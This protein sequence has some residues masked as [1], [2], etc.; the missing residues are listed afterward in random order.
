MR[1]LFRVEVPPTMERGSY[2][3]NVGG[4]NEREARREALEEVN[5]DRTQPRNDTPAPALPRLPPGTQ[6]RPLPVDVGTSEGVRFNTTHPQ[7]YK[8]GWSNTQR[9]IRFKGFCVLCGRWT[10]GHDDGQDDPRGILGDH[11]AAELVA[12]EY[13]MSGP[14]VPACF[15]CQNDTEERYNAVL[16]IAKRRWKAD[17]IA[18]RRTW[19]Q[20][21]LRDAQHATGGQVAD[22]PWLEWLKATAEDEAHTLRDAARELLE[23]QGGRP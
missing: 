15:F 10:F 5:R 20:R 2:T 23:L 16:R 22:M 1:K 14:D 3:F 6:L 21:E 9:V 12:A 18:E 17:P 7:S 13:D 4:D 19:L 11:A 8:D